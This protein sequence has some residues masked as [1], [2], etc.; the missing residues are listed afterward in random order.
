M[1]KRAENPSTY[2]ENNIVFEGDIVITIEE[3]YNY[4]NFNEEMER[5]L[6]LMFTL[7]SHIY[8]QESCHKLPR[9]I[10]D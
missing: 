9:M 10:M 4:Y 5:E 1:G 2:E 3:L 7:K 6:Q 8:Q